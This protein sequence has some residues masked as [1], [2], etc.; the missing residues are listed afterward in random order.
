MAQPCST[1]GSWYDVLD[2]AT[3]ILFSLLEFETLENYK[4]GIVKIVLKIPI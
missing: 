1:Y 2:D 4:L 3:K